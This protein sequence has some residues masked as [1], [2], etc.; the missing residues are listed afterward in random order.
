MSEELL[1]LQQELKRLQERNLYV[2]ECNLRYVSILDML[3]SSNDFQADLNRD[4]DSVSIFRATLQQIK[5]LMEFTYM[6]FYVNSDENDFNLGE[7]DPPARKEELENEVNDRIMDGSFAWTI[8]QNRPVLHSARN[9]EQTLIMHALSTQSR[10]RG[11]FVGLLPGNQS[12]VDAPSLNALSNILVNTA[13]ALESATL[14]DMLRDHMLNLEQKVEERTKELQRARQQAEA[15]NQAKSAFL[16]NMSHELR[17][18]LNATIGFTDVVL[19]KSVGPL[20]VAQEEYLGYV[21]Q[22]SKHLLDLINDI[23]DLSKVEADK[24]ELNLSDVA[25]R[26]L[27]SNS[28][29]MVKELAH[30]SGVKIKEEFSSDIPATVRIDERKVK[31]IIYNLLS[32]AIK[33]TPAGGSVTISVCASIEWP[34]LPTGI[35]ATPAKKGDGSQQFLWITISD[36]GLGLKRDDLERIFKPFEQADNTETRDFEGTGLGLALARKLL[37]LHGGTIW[38]ESPGLGEGSAFHLILPV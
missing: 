16:A 9:S 36:T 21:F 18:P 17:T 3:A 1:A 14:Y 19:S 31:Q 12:T 22:S 5:R 11:M 34:E 4:R 13:Y 30:R 25:I 7:C 32:N 33:F 27:L 26:K 35:H 23:L 8:N 37:E 10:I 15:A 28:L 20:N 6:G 29:I 2:E 38:A 24:M